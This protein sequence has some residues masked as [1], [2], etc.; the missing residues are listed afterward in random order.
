M[1]TATATPV[2]T[3]L[4]INPSSVRRCVRCGL[5]INPRK[6]S[7]KMKNQDMQH[8]TCPAPAEAPEDQ[9]PKDPPTHPEAPGAKASPAPAA[10]SGYTPVYL[11]M[12]EAALLLRV[13]KGT[14]RNRI[15]SGDLPAKRLKGGQTVLVEKQDVLALLEDIV[16]GMEI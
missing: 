16:P 12:D 1:T 14:I 2:P 13:S 7:W 15:K 4:E 5:P 3:E 9:T 6:D 10:T 11:S 8:V